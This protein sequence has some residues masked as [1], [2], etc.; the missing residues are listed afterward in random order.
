MLSRKTRIRLLRRATI[1]IL[2][3]PLFVAPSW[4]EH[5]AMD[6]A[7]EWGGYA[8]LLLGLGLRMWATL[9]IGRRKSKQLVTEGPYSFC[10]NPLYLGTLLIMAGAG[11]C[12][13]N[14]VMLAAALLVAVPAHVLAAKAEE[15]YLEE[16]F[17]QAYRDYRQ[18]VPRFWPRLR[19]YHT[20]ENVEASTW[21]IRR[22]TIETLGVLIIPPIADLLEVLAENHL[23]PIVWRFP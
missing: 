20:V 19:L 16:V 9:F 2:L 23:L 12:L 8:V 4:Q 10:R 15:Q 7:L 13:E 21:A 22:V 14:P 17:G 18:R 3:I 5:H 1:P 11:L 6:F